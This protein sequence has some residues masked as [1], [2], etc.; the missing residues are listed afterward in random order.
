MH[1][2]LP[3]GSSIISWPHLELIEQNMVGMYWRCHLAHEDAQPR[4][5]RARLPQCALE[6]AAK[7]GPQAVA[8]IARTYPT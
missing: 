3:V 1:H 4:L 8:Y 2:V 6:L 7:E 5:P